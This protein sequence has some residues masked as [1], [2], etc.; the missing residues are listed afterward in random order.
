M[1]NLYSFFVRDQCFLSPNSRRLNGKI[2]FAL[3][4]ALY[5]LKKVD[6]ETAV[7]FEWKEA[8]ISFVE[9]IKDQVQ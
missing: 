8:L 6:D 1:D 7:M 2:F 9:G 3:V 5:D 4:V